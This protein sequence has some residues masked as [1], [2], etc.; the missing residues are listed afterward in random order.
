M[1]QQIAKGLSES[2]VCFVFI[3]L[4]YVASKN[5]LM[6]AQFALRT[7]QK[8][9]VIVE[10]GSDLES[11]RKGWRESAIGMLA[12]EYKLVSLLMEQRATGAH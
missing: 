12:N 9:A 4:E 11:A 5:C 1:F 7:L 8:P 3:S 2:S 6:E 10:V